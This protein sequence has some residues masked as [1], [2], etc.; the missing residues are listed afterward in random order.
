M[1]YRLWEFDIEGESH[2]VELEHAYWSGNRLIRID[3]SIV[4]KSRKIIDSG[5]THTF[6]VSDRE[7]SVRIIY[8]WRRPLG[9]SYECTLDGKL[10]PLTSLEKQIN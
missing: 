2:R 6:N 10:V 8:R 4:E 7:C 1:A 3:G 5:S 9:F